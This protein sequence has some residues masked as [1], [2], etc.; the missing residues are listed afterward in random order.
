M[1]SEYVCSHGIQ[2]VGEI[3]EQKGEYS[4]VD[5]TYCGFVHVVPFP[6]EEELAE[7]YHSKFYESDRKKDYFAQQAADREWWCD[8][9]QNRLLKFE[10]AL[11]RKG[12]ILDVGCGPGFFLNHASKAGWDVKGIEPSPRAV[13]FA[14]TELT[15]DV[16][17]GGLDSFSPESLGKFDVV[18]SH[19]VIEHVLRPDDFIKQC[20][21]FLMKGGLLFVN[22]AND[23]NPLQ[24]ALCSKLSYSPWWFVPPEHLNYFSVKSIQGLVERL[25]FQPVYCET[26]FPLELFLLMGDNYLDDPVLGKACHRKRVAFEANMEKAGLGQLKQKIYESFA[27]LGLGRQLDLLAQKVS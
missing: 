27:A 12:R 10:N 9:F 6:S 3:L 11:G 8:V 13:E 18:Y 1:L 22:A 15:V 21:E 16:E 5:C 4:A 2:H 23:F 19:G 20:G 25:G 24:N 26:S 7:Y 14:R 17:Q